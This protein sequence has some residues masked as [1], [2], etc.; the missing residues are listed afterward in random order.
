MKQRIKRIDKNKPSRSLTRIIII[1]VFPVIAFLV[2]GFLL[3]PYGA[4]RFQNN[5]V[6]TIQNKA[7]KEIIAKKMLSSSLNQTK[8]KSKYLQ[9]IDAGEIEKEIMNH[10]KYYSNFRQIR[11]YIED[12]IADYLVRNQLL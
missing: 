6:G 5:K 9:N 8:I 7:E 11:A 10:V 4:M 1:K 2:A 12:I 3:V